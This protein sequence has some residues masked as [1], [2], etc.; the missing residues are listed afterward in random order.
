MGLFGKKGKPPAYASEPPPVVSPADLSNAAVVMDRWD[1]SMGDNAAMW[2]C[3]EA[4][5]RLGGFRGMRAA[6]TE[7]VDG[8]DA[9]EVTNRPWRWWTEASRVALESGDSILAAK[10]FLF[11]YLFVNKI[12]PTMNAATQA[13]VGLGHPGDQSYQ[14]IARLAALAMSNLPPSMLI[15]DTR[16]GKVD[17]ASA[18]AMA[19]S[20]TGS[21]PPPSGAQPPSALVPTGVP[22][23]D[24][25]TLL[26]RNASA[27]DR[28]RALQAFGATVRA[29][30][31]DATAAAAEPGAD[32][33][34]ERAGQLLSEI[35]DRV[36]IR[37]V[38]DLR[39]EYGADPESLAEHVIDDAAT[40]ARWLWTAAKAIPA[41]EPAVHAAKVV[42]HS[43]VEIR[44]VGELIEV[45][46][47]PD[48]D[49][50]A[51]ALP[52]ILAAWVGEVP[53]KPS[54]STPFVVGILVTQTRRAFKDLRGNDGR[55]KGVM[56]RGREG[57]DIIRALGEK[58]NGGLR[59]R[60][61]R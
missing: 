59:Q 48:A 54:W 57:E 12:V 20:V 9:G 49:G 39:R 17:V 2:S 61:I 30:L 40:V 37:S 28:A 8:N 6:L 32:V 47:D 51:A 35:I 5:A 27:A 42:L 33:V 55:I 4:I 50:A 1:R 22:T 16:T 38:A 46:R 60:A 26:R 34:A 25:G 24:L 43:A 41:P 11:A 10:I 3:L 13:D 44:M 18:L 14:N 15:H 21:M 53:G 7:V 45:Y 52:A 36:P 19:H 58:V 29:R 56:N 23:A 31:Q